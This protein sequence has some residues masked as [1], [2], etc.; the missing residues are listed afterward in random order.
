MKISAYD[1]AVYGTLDGH[2]TLISP[3]T[4]QDEVKRD[5]YYYRVFVRTATDALAGKSGQRHPIFPGMIATVDI[6]TG[7][8]TVWAYLTK[9]VHRAAEALRER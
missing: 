6:H 3:D 9:P 5:L 8:K 7:S 4:L 2:V 1:P